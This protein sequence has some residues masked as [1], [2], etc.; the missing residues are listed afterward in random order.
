MNRGMAR[1]VLMVIAVLLVVPSCCAAKMSDEKFMKLCEGGSPA[2][3]KAAIKAGANVHARDD[4]GNTPLHLGAF[5]CVPEVTEM[6][7]KAGADVNAK[8]ELGWTPLHL[9]ALNLSEMVSIL[10]K[11]GADPGAKDNEGNRPID[12]A[13][14]L[15]SKENPYLRILKEASR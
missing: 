1:I 2:A 8:N 4:Y 3:V 12:L 11:A 7:L 6:L 5:Y 15:Y 10:L 9:V 14:G 13:D